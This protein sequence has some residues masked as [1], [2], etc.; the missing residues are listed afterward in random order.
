MWM[1]HSR[2]KAARKGW[3]LGA[4]CMAFLGTVG[5]AQIMVDQRANENAESVK[6]SLPGWPFDFSLPPGQRWVQEVDVG[7]MADLMA[8]VNDSG[9]ALY[10]NQSPWRRQ[11]RL[12]MQYQIVQKGTTSKYAANRVF[13]LPF[14]E[15]DQVELGNLSW[16]VHLQKENTTICG[17]ACTPEGVAICATLSNS[18]DVRDEIELF[19]AVCGS[20]VLRNVD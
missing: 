7:L 20:V 5:L 6:Q 10:I 11:S 4:M 1:Q 9:S 17:V 19:E 8:L 15:F 3:T 13:K 18:S 12:L 14:S 2:E 16:L